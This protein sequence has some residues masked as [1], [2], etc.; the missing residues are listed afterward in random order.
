MGS[1][2]LTAEQRDGTPY[3]IWPC[4]DCLPWHAEAIRDGDEILIREWHAVGCPQF[5]RLIA[6][7][8]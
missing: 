1:V 2:D 6:D 4:H 5:Q 7:G 3:E 8:P